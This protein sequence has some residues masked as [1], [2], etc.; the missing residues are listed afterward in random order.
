MTRFAPIDAPP[1]VRPLVNLLAAANTPQGESVRWQEGS[2]YES[3]AC[4]E[5]RNRDTCDPTVQSLVKDGVD[6]DDPEGRRVETVAV[7]AETIY[8]CMVIPALLDTYRERVIAAADA[9]L[10]R[11]VEHELWTGA[12]AR[13]AAL[14][15]RYLIDPARVT[16]LNGGVAVKPFAALGLLEDALGD[17]YSGAGIVHCNRHAV[18]YLPGVTR[19][20]RIIET[21]V[22]NRVVPGVGYPGLGPAT[23]GDPD[24]APPGASE[25]WVYITPMVTARVGTV[26][27]LDRVSIDRDTNRAQ[28][29]ARTP[30]EVSWDGCSA[31]FAILMQTV[32]EATP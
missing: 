6:A 30:F 22:G 18:Q 14:P 10:P 23:V 28:I 19:N 20:G 26:E 5:V 9:E 7:Y 11:A 13:G 24:G 27:V 16:V 4:M 12:I 32:V 15:N 21:R 25:E 3:A 29:R 8:E 17:V 1:V 2:V 31:A